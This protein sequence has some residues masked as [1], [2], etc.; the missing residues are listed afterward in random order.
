MTG[1]ALELVRQ[2][3]KS[4]QQRAS[5]KHGLRSHERILEARETRE[6]IRAS[7]NLLTFVEKGDFSI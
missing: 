3:V 4:R 6:L 1:E 2:R 5:W 7:K